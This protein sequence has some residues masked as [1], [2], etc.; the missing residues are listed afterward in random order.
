MVGS[1]NC[2][3][4]QLLQNEAHQQGIAHWGLL[5]HM[6][7]VSPAEQVIS[8]FKHMVCAVL[9]GVSVE[10]R[11]IDEAFIHEAAEFM[12]YV[13]ECFV[14]SCQ[15]L[16]DTNLHMCFKLNLSVLAWK[17][18]LVPFRTAGYAWIPE[19]LHSSHG[20]KHVTAE[21]VICLGWQEMYS[22]VCK[23]LTLLGTVQHTTKV[24]WHHDQL[25]GKFLP[26]HERDMCM[27]MP[28]TSSVEYDHEVV[29]HLWD[30]LTG[31]QKLE[32]SEEAHE[33]ESGALDGD[34]FPQCAHS[35]QSVMQEQVLS[36][37]QKAG[38]DTE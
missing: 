32:A 14:H 29:E 5:P 2:G 34:K 20:G 24:T 9:A 15:H 6:F 7:R 21:P 18:G 27:P 8:H 38:C 1:D 30:A 26:A 33:R 3:S 36:M 4:M 12:C 31:P 16:L 19:S 10:D 37:V 35:L 11:P 17:G 28:D 22:K 23:V 13:N 25:L